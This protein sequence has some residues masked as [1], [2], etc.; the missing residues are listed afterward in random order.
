MTLSEETLKA[1]TAAGFDVDALSA[2]IAAALA[3]D[4]SAGGGR[5]IAV[6][7]EAQTPAAAPARSA[8]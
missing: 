5:G 8:A 6:T 4:L 1:F 3:E 2:S 7:Y